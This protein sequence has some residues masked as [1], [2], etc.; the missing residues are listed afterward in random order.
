MF[1]ELLLNTVNIIF[2]FLPSSVLFVIKVAQI[3]SYAVKM[4]WLPK[5]Y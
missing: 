2:I 4:Q 3:C 5:T 1:L